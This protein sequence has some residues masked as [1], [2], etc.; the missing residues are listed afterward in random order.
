PGRARCHRRLRGGREATGRAGWDRPVD[1]RWNT[2][3]H[4]DRKTPVVSCRSVPTVN[5]YAPQGTETV[6]PEWNHSGSTV[7]PGSVL[8]DSVLDFVSFVLPGR[9]GRGP[10]REGHLLQTGRPAGAR[11]AEQLVELAVVESRGSSVVTV[12]AVNDTVHTRPQRRGQTQW[13]RLA[14]GDQHTT[15]QPEITELL[16]GTT[17]RDDLGVC[18][19]IRCHCHQIGAGRDDLTGPRDQR[20]ERTATRT[21]TVGGQP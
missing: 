3:R 14:R 8:D 2:F 5:R 6:L 10:L 7:L 15:V 9:E 19:G 4:R 17:N 13:T 20:T 1:R 12:G 11:S 16:A 18:R 21:D